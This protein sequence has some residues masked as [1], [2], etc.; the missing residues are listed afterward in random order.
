MFERLIETRSDLLPVVEVG[1]DDS[2][3]VLLGGDAMLVPQHRLAY[4]Q[5]S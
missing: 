4:L 5:S 3:F 1:A 2:R